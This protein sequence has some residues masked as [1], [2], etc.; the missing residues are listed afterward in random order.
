MA[1]VSHYD[2][3]TG[4]SVTRQMT[5]EEQAIYDAQLA[6]AQAEAE[7]EA[8]KSEARQAVLDKLGLTA[9]EAAALLG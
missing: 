2:H 6:E 7:A 8:V 1:T 9:D 4:Q 3:A 5:A